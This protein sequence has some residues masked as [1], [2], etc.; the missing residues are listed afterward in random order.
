MKENA[1]KQFILKKDCQ[2]YHINVAIIKSMEITVEDIERNQNMD[3]E[4]IIEEI[5]KVSCNL[6]YK[7]KHD[8]YSIEYNKSS[9]TCYIHIYSSSLDKAIDFLNN[10]RNT[11]IKLLFE[12]DKNEN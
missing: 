10:A 7:N 1:M 5:N 12:E 2:L 6:N 3:K 11:F 9:K 8:S 4:N